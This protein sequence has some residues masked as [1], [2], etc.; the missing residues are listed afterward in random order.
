MEK[1][2]V[3]NNDRTRDSFNCKLCMCEWE[4]ETILNAY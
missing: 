3:D 4:K 1:M 2:Y